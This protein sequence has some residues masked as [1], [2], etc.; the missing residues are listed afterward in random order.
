MCKCILCC[1]IIMM[2][3]E[4]E[5][6][7]FWCFTHNRQDLVY[8]AQMIKEKKCERESV[9][10]FVRVCT[11]VG[12]KKTERV[13]SIICRAVNWFTMYDLR[14][15]EIWLLSLTHLF[16]VHV[17]VYISIYICMYKYAYKD[18]YN[19]V[20]ICMFIYAYIYICA[21]IY[22]YIKM[23]SSQFYAIWMSQIVSHPNHYM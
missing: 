16:I 23:E 12:M 8:Y 3:C 9:C 11:C 5:S 7:I 21:F 15:T 19:Y 10:A 13:W 2:I 14:I 22:I 1:C 18:I 6:V 17:F 20:Y 4:I